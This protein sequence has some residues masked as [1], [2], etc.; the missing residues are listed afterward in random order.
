MGLRTLRLAMLLCR[1]FDE[2]L[3]QTRF[4]LVLDGRCQLQ[5]VST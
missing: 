5:K 3:G 1:C 2:L 4:V